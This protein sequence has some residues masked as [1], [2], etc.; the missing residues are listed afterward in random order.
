M[1]ECDLVRARV[2]EGSRAVGATRGTLL[3]PLSATRGTLLTPLGTLPTLCTLPRLCK[4]LLLRLPVMPALPVLLPMVLPPLPPLPPLL[5]PPLPPP[6]LPLLLLLLPLL[7][8]PLPPPPPPFISPVRAL[9]PPRPT[10]LLPAE[11]ALLLVAS[12][13]GIS[14]TA[15]SSRSPRPAADLAAE[16]PRRHGR[17]TDGA[18][19]DGGTCT[20][21]QTTLIAN[22]QLVHTP[23]NNLLVERIF[24][25]NSMRARWRAQAQSRARD[26]GSLASSTT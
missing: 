21:D 23:L 12:G 8:L 14:R 17:T 24:R 20:R 5:P 22:W 26:K 16:S 25:R 1:S 7:T 3:T 18:C 9:P 2:G 4:R 19:G 15:S 6:L 13:A 11:V 10:S